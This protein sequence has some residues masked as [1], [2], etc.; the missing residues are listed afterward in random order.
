MSAAIGINMVFRHASIL[1][2]HCVVFYGCPVFMPGP[3][4]FM[5]CNQVCRLRAISCS[6]G[7]TGMAAE[8][9]L[10][11]YDVIVGEHVSGGLP[12]W[13]PRTEGASDSL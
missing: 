1:K 5:C 2:N 3:T 9:P 7:G 13:S 12:E 8:K 10:A 6:I 11:S 4:G